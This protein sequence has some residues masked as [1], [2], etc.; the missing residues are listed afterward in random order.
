MKDE[1]SR[2]LQVLLVSE[3]NGNSAETVKLRQL[4]ESVDGLSVGIER[5][6]TNGRAAVS[7]SWAVVVVV[8]SEMR[9]A[10]QRRLFEKLETRGQGPVVVAALESEADSL[11]RW[12]D[13]GA[14]DYFT[15]PWELVNILPR[16]R[17]AVRSAA[18]QPG[19]PAPG[20]E[21]RALEQLIGRSPALRG[22]VDRIPAIAACDASVLITGETGTGKE[23]C[24]RAIHYLGPRSQKPFV[25]L[26]C[27][28]IPADLME[29]ELF[30]HTPGAYTSANNRQSGLIH[31][32]E[33]G[34]LFL[35]EVDSLPFSV[36]VKL[37]RFLQNKEYRP[38]GSSQTLTA[39]VRVV[40]A[41]NVDPAAA[42][43]NGKLRQDL[44]YRLNVVPLKLP[45]L[46]E[47][48]VDIPLLAGHFLRRYAKEYGK[49][50]SAL[51]EEAMNSLMSHDWP[52]NI[53]ELENVIARMVVL[54]DSECLQVE[55][56]DLPEDANSP[57]ASLRTAKGQ[58]ERAYIEQKLRTCG[59][60]IS[61]AAKAAGKNRRS[62]WELIRKH[63]IEVEKFRLPASS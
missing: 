35:D 36:Q 49:R 40:A 15:P 9:S 51:S 30:G 28:A 59:G 57:D 53:R 27:G 31:E 20:N 37:L 52:G 42:V 18:A 22:V 33:W 14:V 13:W 23:L 32:A 21:E 24:A 43:Q 34:T 29:N 4:L 17:K 3:A 46:R 44:Y 50:V 16:L 19:V 11:D 5:V 62:F 55:S 48:R 6:S 54:A 26:N 25:P 58:F 2:S 41:T 63:Q 10:E 7:H 38:L 12:I 60:N 1:R 45:P 8:T 39:N 61:R 56:L 47:R